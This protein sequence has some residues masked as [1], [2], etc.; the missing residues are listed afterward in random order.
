[1][2]FCADASRTAARGRR[3][4][5]GAP[6]THACCT[7]R[8]CSEMCSAR[9]GGRQM[10]KA[11]TRRGNKARA[12]TRAKQGHGGTRQFAHTR[13]RCI[14]LFNGVTL[15]AGSD[16]NHAPH[17]R[18]RGAR[19]IKGSL[20]WDRITAAQRMEPHASLP[21][22]AL[23]L[24][25]LRGLTTWPDSDKV[26]VAQAS[27]RRLG[28]FS[29]IGRATVT[30]DDLAGCG[31]IKCGPSGGPSATSAGT[32]PASKVSDHWKAF[33]DAAWDSAHRVWHQAQSAGKWQSGV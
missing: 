31:L 4:C 17:P 25:G 20:N 12:E 23:V 32:G 33:F 14:C 3:Q 18:T 13:Q 1:M 7:G 9:L 2:P 28:R 16:L 5:G 19:H 6:R 22:L 21:M 10:R 26:P 11:K 24:V 29:G 15:A 30:G 8:P 27:E